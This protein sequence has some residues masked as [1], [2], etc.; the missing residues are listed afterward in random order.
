MCEGR[1]KSKLL[2]GNSFAAKS[3]SQPLSSD[4][5]L[6]L[7]VAQ[8]KVRYFSVECISM[9]QLFAKTPV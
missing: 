2:Q 3:R 1:L 9:V 7:V 5:W 4:E 8:A 6:H